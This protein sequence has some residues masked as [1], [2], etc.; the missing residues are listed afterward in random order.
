MDFS[1]DKD[2]V[3]CIQPRKYIKKLLANYERLFG[4]MPKTARI[5]S[6]LVEGDHPEL[7]TSDLL[8]S[9]GIQ[10]YQSLIGSIQWVVSIGRFDVH[11][12]IAT[13]SSFRVAPRVGHLDRIKR[14]YAYLHRMQ[15][16]SIRICMDEPDY[17]QVPDQTYDWSATYGSGPM[18]IPSDAP[19]P[20]GKF[21]TLTHYVDANLMH[22][23]LTGRL[24]TCILH[25]MNKFPVDWY[26]KK[27][28]TVETAT[29][30]S[31]MVAART[32]TKQILDL[33]L[34]LIYLGVPL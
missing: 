3:L 10:L 23:M 15:H 6:P 28:G 7:D 16:A 30:G 24:M 18:E 5:C 14:I 22:C 34:S 11:T 32:C 1:R 8:D 26:A 21:I 29:Y 33:R 9:Q 20:L 13:L 2:N 4:P 25:M 27:Q 17:S 31:E 12:A 19:K